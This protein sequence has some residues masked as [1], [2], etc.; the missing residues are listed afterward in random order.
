[1][2][3]LKI[4]ATCV[5]A[6]AMTLSSSSLLA[7]TIRVAGTYTQPIQQKRDACLHLALQALEGA[8]EIDYADSEKVANTDYVRV[9]REYS[10]SG[11]DR[12]IVEAFG[13]SRKARKVASDYPR[14]G[15]PHG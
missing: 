3:V 1:M 7:E 11:V 15:L 2:S 9:L 4:A 14:D 13:I 8:G 5:L 6:S 10:E 12:I